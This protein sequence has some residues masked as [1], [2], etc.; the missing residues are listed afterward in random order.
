MADMERLRSTLVQVMQMLNDN[1]PQN[2]TRK[3]SESLE[4]LEAER[5]SA[6]TSKTAWRFQVQP[7]YLNPGGSMQGGAHAAFHDVLTSWTFFLFARPGFWRT[8]VTRV[9]TVTYF[10]PAMP[11]DWIRAECEV[12]GAGKR[13]GT[14]NGKFIREK[15]G[16]II[17]TCAHEK[18]NTDAD[19]KM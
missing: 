6:S 11:G 8:H 15:D 7:E 10:R 3:W 5:T 1:S 4:L 18:Y 16:A 12:I 19:S 14:V 17:S 13:M 2:F 9:L